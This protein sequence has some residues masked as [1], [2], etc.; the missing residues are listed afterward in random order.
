MLIKEL[1]DKGVCGK[2][3]I[4]NLAIANVNMINHVIL[5]SI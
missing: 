3:Y 5:V 1:I 4:W 2:D